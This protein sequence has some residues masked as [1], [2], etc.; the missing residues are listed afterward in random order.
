M[1][2]EHAVPLL[3]QYLNNERNANEIKYAAALALSEIASIEALLALKHAEANHPVVVVQTVAREALWRHGIAQEPATPEPPIQMVPQQTVPSGLPK[4]LVFIKGEREPGNSD[5]ISKDMTSYSVTDGGPTYRLGRNLFTIDTANPEGSLKQL[6]QFES[7]YVADLEVS[8]DGNKLLFTRA[9]MDPDPWF[10][11]YEMN[12]DGTDLKQLT[13][14]P[15]H[16]T[17]PNYMPDGRIVF[18]S[19]RTGMRD[20]YHGYPSNGLA[21][22]NRDGSD[23]QVIGFNIGRDADPV[24]GDDGMI[25]FTRLELFYSRMKTEWN[26]LA[27]FPDGRSTATL[28]G[29]ERRKMHVKIPGA[30]AV[31][32]P[33]HRGVRLSQPQSWSGSEYLLNT[34]KGPMLAGPGR[35]K[36]RFLRPNNDWAV[37]TP[38][39]ISESLMLVA[40]GERPLHEQ[41]DP[42]GKYKAGAPDYNAS[43][44]HGLYR[45]NPEDGEL[46]LIYN[47]P[48]QAD[49]EARPLQPRKVPPVL[50]ES[51]LTRNRGFSGQV[52]CASAF[53]TQSPHV[54][55]RGK[56]V[57]VVEGIPTIARHQTHTS[58]G[59]AW[60]NHGGAV[61]RILGTVPL[62]VDGSFSIE[63]PSDRLYHLQ[64]LD[65]DRRV[66]GNQLIWQYVRPQES[67]SCIGCH[68][69]PD[70]APPLG[71]KL[72]L[73]AS[74][75]S[76]PMLPFRR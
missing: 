30:I 9:T 49:F 67:K 36:D 44:D 68:E 8:Y 57:R 48:L 43:V 60:R 23:I 53:T 2:A 29:P 70:S 17:H 1:K 75:A 19:S 32:P 11:I 61:G 15:Y 35:Y 71:S 55:E 18:T 6:T 45:M 65:S 56:Y 51:P 24:I 76:G 72:P 74:N 54:K 34:F 41:D 42:K 16:D 39:K 52:H 28:Y 59:I 5:Q 46:T 26:L 12:A 63:I 69:D 73:I 64:V 3:I 7:G 66:L 25:L 22:M 37:T 20:E 58:G 47:D 40:A 27:A 62:A 14:G 10:H 4:R 31:T 50:T 13:F 38:Y 33:R 21:V